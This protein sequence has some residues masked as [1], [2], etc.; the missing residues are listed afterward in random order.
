MI[1]TIYIKHIITTLH[2]QKHKILKILKTIYYMKV[3]VIHYKL[4]PNFIQ[5]FQILQTPNKFRYVIMLVNII[6]AVLANI[7]I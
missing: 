3:S 2:P 7:L 6:H 5:H 4:Q 1:L